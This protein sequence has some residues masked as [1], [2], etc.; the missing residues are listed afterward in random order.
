MAPEWKWRRAA[1]WGVPM[2]V[3]PPIPRSGVN[4]TV[5]LDK[6]L[7]TWYEESIIPDQ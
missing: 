1:G 3:G 7:R 4:P 2:I 5:W 6:I